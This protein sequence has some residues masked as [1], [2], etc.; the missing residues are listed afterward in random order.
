M[1]NYDNYNFLKKNAEY[2]KSK[3]SKL[4][5]DRRNEDIYKLKYILQLLNTVIK[6]MEIIINL[7]I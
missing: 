6:R 4:H 3:I 1:D 2:L 7:N 5:K